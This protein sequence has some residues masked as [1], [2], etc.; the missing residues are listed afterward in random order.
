MYHLTAIVEGYGSI[1]GA[2]HSQ[3]FFPVAGTTAR[4]WSG[5]VPG[6]RWVKYYTC[7][8][9]WDCGSSR[10]KTLSRRWECGCRGPVRVDA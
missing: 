1:Q 10:N 8:A 5:A 9:V 6:F 7:I 4:G 2:G 3:L